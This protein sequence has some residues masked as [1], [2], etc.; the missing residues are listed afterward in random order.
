MN[1]TVKDIINTIIDSI[2]NGI[3]QNTVDTLKCGNPDMIVSGIASTFTATVEVIKQ[4][5]ILGDNLIITH[6]P[7]FFDHYDEVEK[8]L[9]NDSIV[10]KKKKLL[11]QKNIAVWRF[12]DN[13]HRN[14]PDG[15][16][17]G[18]VKKLNWQ[19]Y[20]SLNDPR[21]FIRKEQY[22]RDLIE[23]LK[24][25]FRMKTIRVIGNPDNKIKK[26]A[27]IL[28]A[29]GGQ[30]QIKFIS[31]HPEID[32]VVCGETVEWQTCEYIRD[33]ASLGR[34]ISLIILGHALSEQ[35]GMNYLV[36]WLKPKFAGLPIHYI[37]VP[38]LFS[39]F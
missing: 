17:T 14:I 1:Y 10:E 33:S 25:V 13:W 26:I 30:Y 12:H 2:P 9:E 36:E 7:T 38:D 34:K 4:A 16:L 20:Q 35:E 24:T 22:L 5:E 11:I 23:E 19:N 32:A 37:E 27:L 3:R 21:I 6:E 28:G 29:Y 15:I 8:W 18:I 39:F 31:E